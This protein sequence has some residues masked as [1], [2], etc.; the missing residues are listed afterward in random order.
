MTQ[1]VAFE[2]EVGGVCDRDLGAATYIINLMGQSEAEPKKAIK[3]RLGRSPD[4]GDA[5]SLCTYDSTLI[6]QRVLSVQRSIT[7]PDDPSTVLRDL[8]E[9]TRGF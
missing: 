1:L 3:K 7:T 4:R 6:T 9:R 2:G 5:F 8:G